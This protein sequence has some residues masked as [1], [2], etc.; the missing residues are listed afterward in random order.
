[1]SLGRSFE[2]S[3]SRKIMRRASRRSWV[4]VSFWS[5][6]ASITWNK[7][8]IFGMAGVSNLKSRK[9]SSELLL[10]NLSI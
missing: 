6:H 8:T 5:T 7:A 4:E 1:M 2:I 3:N 9:L 10:L